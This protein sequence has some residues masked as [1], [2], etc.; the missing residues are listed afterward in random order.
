[1]LIIKY[2]WKIKIY[3]KA[4][5]VWIESKW[6][7]TLPYNSIYYKAIAIKHIVAL[8]EIKSNTPMMEQ[9]KSHLCMRLYII[10]LTSQISGK[11]IN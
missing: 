10:K 1:M 9:K 7:L 8:L 6:E 5:N 4:K 3:K 2:V 11:R